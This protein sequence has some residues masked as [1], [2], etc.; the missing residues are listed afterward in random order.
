MSP[1][2][3]YLYNR[4][5]YK[6]IGAA[7][8]LSTNLRNHIKLVSAND[9]EIVFVIEAPRYDVNKFTKTGKISYT[10]DRPDY[11]VWLNDLGAFAKHNKSEHWVNRALFEMCHEV[12]NALGKKRVEVINDLPLEFGANYL[13]KSGTKYSTKFKREVKVRQEPKRK[14]ILVGVDANG[15][16]VYKWIDRS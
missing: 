4:M 3:L 14:R 7:P 6:L 13:K 16:N 9:T 12:R 15:K 5:P 2:M 1:E 11:A 8:V 10:G